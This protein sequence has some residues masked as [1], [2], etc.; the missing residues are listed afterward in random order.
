MRIYLDVFVSEYEDAISKGAILDKYIMK[1]YIKNKENLYKYIKPQGK[2]LLLKG[3][4]CRVDLCNNHI[5]DGNPPYYKICENCYKLVKKLNLD[6]NY[7]PFGPYKNKNMKK[8]ITSKSILD[9]LHLRCNLD[10]KE[11]TKKLDNI[12]NIK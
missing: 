7:E 2:W 3:N 9:N 11:L 8:P 4:K 12:Y 10:N 6:I 5:T 1:I